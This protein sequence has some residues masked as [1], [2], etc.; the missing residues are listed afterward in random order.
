MVY[1]KGSRIDT[2]EPLPARYGSCV[3][4]RPR[5]RGR[6][7]LWRS[8]LCRCLG[9]DP[10]TS[11]NRHNKGT[12][13]FPLGPIIGSARIPPTRRFFSGHLPVAESR[14]A[15]KVILLHDLVE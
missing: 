13:C 9:W 8:G 12:Q 11:I 14:G 1:S 7:V 3:D 10:M 4:L 15:G 6:P 5:P 2:K